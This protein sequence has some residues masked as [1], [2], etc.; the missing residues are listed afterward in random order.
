MRLF[1]S[2]LCLLSIAVPSAAVNADGNANT[3]AISI[4]WALYSSKC[5]APETNPNWVAAGHFG[6][7]YFGP[8]APESCG[9][10]PITSGIETGAAVYPPPGNP[11]PNH[12][13]AEQTCFEPQATIPL[14]NSD[15]WL[16]II[17]FE[18]WHG[19][20]VAAT[21]LQATD[22][23]I[24]AVFLPLDNPLTGSEGVTDADL[25]RP[26]A[27]L[28]EWMD[29]EGR[30]P[31]LVINMSFGRRASSDDA[32]DLKCAPATLSCQV[33]RLLHHLERG[34]QDPT[35]PLRTVAIASAGNHRSLL[36]PAMIDHVLTAG[37][38]ELA[39]YTRSGSTKGSWETPLPDSGQLVLMP[40]SALCIP[41]QGGETR[42]AVPSGTSFAT[43]I[44]TGMIADALL[45]HDSAV[46]NRLLSGSTWYPLR[47]CYKPNCAIEL[48]QGT[49]TFPTP[50]FG[51]TDLID[52][53]LFGDLSTCD[54][55]WQASKMVSATLSSTTVVPYLKTPSLVQS[56][57][58]TLRPTPEP[59]PCVPCSLTC[60]ENPFTTL[61][62]SAVAISRKLTE[63]VSQPPG[64]VVVPPNTS[65]QLTIDLHAGWQLDPDTSVEAL[66]LRY[67]SQTYEIQLTP[68]ELVELAAGQIATLV[69]KGSV[70]NPAMIQQP[71]L[72]SVLLHKNL[73]SGTV[74]RFWHATPMPLRAP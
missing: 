42:W 38:L 8:E 29:K 12:P 34:G 30:K 26:L 21:A 70:P 60:E 28:A 15:P 11:P 35:L 5:I 59:D 7:F 74:D 45:W 51:A 58:A 41:W 63:A 48:A 22:P 62:G 24:R 44:A 23:S 37:S 57:A 64:A 10:P 36:F 43:A 39:A 65:V 47:T 9:G 69:I 52:Y 1:S 55:Q 67:G 40:G 17:D 31:A 53:T 68:T 18:G 27:T 3:G 71:S 46:R 72:I 33:S 14:A 54:E 61:S 49:A 25:I 13:C 32:S 66:Y 2:F 20:S 6:T 56:V 4:H 73:A 19:E 50:S 16:A